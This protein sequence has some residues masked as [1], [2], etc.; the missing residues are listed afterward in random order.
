MAPARLLLLAAAAAAQRAD[1]FAALAGRVDW[2][3]T[4]EKG[5][6][7]TRFTWPA[8]SPLRHFG[9]GGDV[10]ATLRGQHV[11]F[12]GNSVTRHLVVALHALLQRKPSEPPVDAVPAASFTL[13]DAENSV[14]VGHGAASAEVRG[15]VEGVPF[16]NRGIVDDECKHAQKGLR[17]PGCVINCCL[18]NRKHKDPN[19]TILTYAYTGTPSEHNIR[20][21]LNNWRGK[22]HCASSLAPDFVVLGLTTHD[23]ASDASCAARKCG[24]GALIASIE[25]LLDAQRA[26]AKTTTFLMVT[27]PHKKKSTG[28]VLKDH[29]AATLALA[30]GTRVVVVPVT[31]ASARGMSAG[32]LVHEGSNYYHFGDPGRYFE[33]HMVLNAIR[34]ARRVRGTL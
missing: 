27:A 20:T 21:A 33:A 13:R 22:D 1:P 24:A 5:K 9:G 14:W 10:A 29:E 19:S 25:A 6:K 4:K 28:S 16:H 30:A 17:F 34:I 7:V 18:A 15:H 31:S 32:A 23:N 26:V 11:L 3:V 2:T 8:G 12:L